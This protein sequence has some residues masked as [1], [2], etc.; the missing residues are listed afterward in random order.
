MIRLY[1]DESLLNDNLRNVMR[2]ERNLTMQMG[3]FV[4]V[5]EAFS[6][7]EIEYANFNLLL[8]GVT[9]LYD[10]L[11]LQ[12]SSLMHQ[13]VMPDQYPTDMSIK[14]DVSSMMNVKVRG[15]I[16]SVGYKIV[17]TIPEIRDRFVLYEVKALPF[18]LQR[19]LWGN[20]KV[21]RE[22]VAVDARGRSFEYDARL[23]RGIGSSAICSPEVLEVHC[24]PVLCAEEL[25]VRKT[26]GSICVKDMEI[27]VPVRQ[28]YLHQS[29]SGLVSIYS[30]M[31]DTVRIVCASVN[32]AVVQDIG[33]GIT[34]LKLPYGCV[35]ESSELTI[36]SATDSVFEGEVP[37]IFNAD[38][39]G[40]VYN[41]T[42]FI[43]YVHELNMS[44]IENDFDKY[45]V[46]V[47]DTGIDLSEVK[48]SLAKFKHISSLKQYNPMKIDW[49]D[50][51]ALTNVTTVSGV[52]VTILLIVVI[53]YVCCRCCACCAPCWKLCKCTVRFVVQECSVA[54]IG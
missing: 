24:K 7:V 47:N 22:L 12:L 52:L 6:D 32:S 35:A 38:L 27:F 14:L 26:I 8:Q 42:N 4:S 25:V 43:E 53:V 21:S 10:T 45:S 16:D 33:S 19:N 23:C 2:D 50:P 13:R 46:S 11:E 54:L 17:Y 49:E 30:N 20:L 37:L 15:E 28:G 5:L 48:E 39:S 34:V 29:V 9:M 40:E 1:K 41:L 31:N 18:P 44:K 36:Y 3:V 51:Y